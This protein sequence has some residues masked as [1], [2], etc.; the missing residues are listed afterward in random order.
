VIYVVRYS[1]LRVRYFCHYVFLCLFV[2]CVLSLFVF[3]SFVTPFFIFVFARYVCMYI[4]FVF[5]LF[6]NV[7][8]V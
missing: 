5:A 2:Y 4:S 7:V 3:R 6:R 8:F 1:F